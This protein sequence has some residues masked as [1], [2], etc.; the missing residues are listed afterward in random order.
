LGL[1]TRGKEKRM[2]Y[3]LPHP[4]Q[5]S[6]ER[7]ELSLFPQRGPGGDPAENGI[8]VILSPQFASVDSR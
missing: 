6:G 1:K 3:P 2:R 4:T 8:I 7:R 5:G